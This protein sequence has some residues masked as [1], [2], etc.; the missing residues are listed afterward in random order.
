ML[1][2]QTCFCVRNYGKHVGLCCSFLKTNFSFFHKFNRPNFEC[3]L[4][5]NILFIDLNFKDC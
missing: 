2:D 4:S 3:T 1:F 5:H